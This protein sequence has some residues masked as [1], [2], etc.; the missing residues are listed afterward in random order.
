MQTA[1]TTI[2]RMLRV[3]PSDYCNIPYPNIVFRDYDSQTEALNDTT[4]YNPNEPFQ[5]LN[6]YEEW[7]N[8]VNPGD[9]IYF[10]DL[11]KAATIIEVTNAGTIRINTSDIFVTGDNPEYT[12]YQESTT[13]N[14]GCQLYFSDASLTPSISITSAGGDFEVNGSGF[15]LKKVQPGLLPMQ[16]IKLWETDTTS[17]DADFYALW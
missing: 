3:I 13:P 7:V 10:D 2:T 11:Y 4:L 6:A 5:V 16:V 14:R 8:I 12:I 9:I 15:V 17:G 1:G